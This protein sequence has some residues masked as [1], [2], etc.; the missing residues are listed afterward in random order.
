MVS[1]VT[2]SEAYNAVRT[3]ANPSAPRSN[4]ETAARQPEPRGRVLARN[5]TIRRRAR[6]RH[7]SSAP[8][9]W[10]P[11]ISVYPSDGGVTVTDRSTLNPLR[12]VFSPQR[13]GHALTRGHDKQASQHAHATKTI[14]HPPTLPAESSVPRPTALNRQRPVLNPTPPSPRRRPH[15]RNAHVSS[16]SPL[17]KAHLT[18]TGHTHTPHEEI[19]ARPRFH[20]SPHQPRPG[21]RTCHA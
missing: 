12:A 21:G 15:K 4:R 10:R 14:L 19:R 1:S 9:T 20:A 18:H 6:R 3:C 17:R 5:T 2:K 16:N 11:V 8:L 7:T 13:V